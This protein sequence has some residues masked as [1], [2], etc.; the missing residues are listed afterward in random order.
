MN[1]FIF[2]LFK[3]AIKHSFFFFFWHEI[4]FK[5][6]QVAIEVTFGD[7]YLQTVLYVHGNID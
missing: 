1:I 4:F 6:R 5:V 3:K 7:N 2:V